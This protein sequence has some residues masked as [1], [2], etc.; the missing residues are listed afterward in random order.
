MKTRAV[1]DGLA[2]DRS[3]ASASSDY[4]GIAGQIL[5]R[6]GVRETA[7]H[8]TALV[9]TTMDPAGSTFDPGDAA[10]FHP[11]RLSN[12]PLVLTEPSSTELPLRV[13]RK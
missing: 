11:R 1:R 12:H 13:V 9:V 6:L 4:S 8:G 3:A 2:L 5:D 10:M 7:I